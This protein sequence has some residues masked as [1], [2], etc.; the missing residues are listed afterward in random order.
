MKAEEFNKLLELRIQH[1]RETLVEKA[2]EY[3]TDDRLHN[4]KEAAGTFELSP[5]QVCW[6][7]MMKHLIS[8]KDLAYGRKVA[9]PTVVRE[10]IGDAINYLILMEA[11]FLEYIVDDV[12][13]NPEK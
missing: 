8:I 3:A 1:I 5:S 10:K 13:A 6:D 7:Y 9:F 11:I 4:F 2:K 12:V